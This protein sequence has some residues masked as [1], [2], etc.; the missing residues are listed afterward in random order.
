[1]D[2]QLFAG[3]GC[4][5]GI[6]MK[7]SKAARGFFVPR[8]SALDLIM[9]YHGLDYRDAQFIINWM[10]ETGFD[11]DEDYDNAQML[12][13]AGQMIDWINKNGDWP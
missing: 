9:G 12:R 4:G 8:G 13:E 11:F 6:P 5:V 10:T 1:M 7:T 2:C 3:S